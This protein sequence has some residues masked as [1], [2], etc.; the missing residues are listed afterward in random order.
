VFTAA[1]TV[2][3]Q[4]E[5]GALVEGRS[6]PGR[7][8]ERRLSLRGH[9]SPAN[10]NRTEGGGRRDDQN[11]AHAGTLSWIA[12]RRKGALLLTLWS[13]GDRH[14]PRSRQADELCV[15]TNG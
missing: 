2:R 13:R 3:L 7:F 8:G 4:V 15:N 14:P 11:L 9:D 5:G 12:V 6:C 1:A 10:Q